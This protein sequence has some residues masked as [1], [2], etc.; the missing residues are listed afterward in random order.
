LKDEYEHLRKSIIL[1]GLCSK[2]HPVMWYLQTLLH[3]FSKHR[4]NVFVDQVGLELVA[5]DYDMNSP[6]PF[7]KS[8]IV[9]IVPICKVAYYWN[10]LKYLCV[11]W[12][13]CWL[14]LLWHCLLFQHVVYS[15]IDSRNLLESSKMALD[16]GKLDDAVNYGAKVCSGQPFPCLF[17]ISFNCCTIGLPAF[18]LV[19][20]LVCHLYVWWY[21][22][23]FLWRPCPKL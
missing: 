5:R 17:C 9:N 22:L 12:M 7:D 19:E 23:F 18:C 21:T 11:Y 13:A 10:L 3:S 16:K 1:R 4:T 20:S 6:N 2:V 8:D 14:T 15:S